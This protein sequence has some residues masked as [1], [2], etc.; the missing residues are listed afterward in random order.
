MRFDNF[1]AVSDFK[2]T[3]AR[4]AF[5]GNRFGRC[6]LVICRAISKLQAH[7]FAVACFWGK[8]M[9]LVCFFAICRMISELQ[10]RKYTGRA[11]GGISDVGARSLFLE[12]YLIFGN[13]CSTIGVHRSA[14]DPPR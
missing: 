12:L 4:G 13:R 9:L 7:K 2:R 11:F 5:L 3:N 1:R 10:M 8:L 6:A 14:D